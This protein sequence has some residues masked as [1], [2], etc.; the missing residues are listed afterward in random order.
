MIN[1]EK[2]GKK[3]KGDGEKEREMKR[4]DDWTGR[5]TDNCV[6]EQH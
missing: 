6:V 5:L 1:E 3:M 2:G 4:R